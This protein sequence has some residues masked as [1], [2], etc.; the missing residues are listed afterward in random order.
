MDHRVGTRPGSGR[1]NPA[2]AAAA[3]PRHDAGRSRD[4]DAVTAHEPGPEPAASCDPQQR[5]PGAALGNRTGHDAGLDRR[6]PAAPSTPAPPAAGEPRL[7]GGVAAPQR[8]ALGLLALVAACGGGEAVTTAKRP[9][10]PDI[11]VETAA[12]EVKGHLEE[13]YTTLEG[14]NKDSLFSLLAD[15]L[16]A[17][18]PRPDDAL[19][20]RADVLT[21][22]GELVD[23]KEKKTVKLRSK[24]PTVVVAKGGRSAW[25]TDLVQV[26]GT[27]TAATIVLT[28]ADDLWLVETVAIA[29][30]PSAEELTSGLTAASIVPPGA[31][32]EKQIATDAKAAVA[33]FQAGLLDQEQWG[34][35]LAQRADAI[36]IGPAEGEVA[37]GKK[38]IKKRWKQR[39]EA[40]TRLALAGDIAAAVTADGQ[41]AWVSAPVT[42]ATAE[43]DPV[44]VRAF[45][46]Y[47]LTED[48][49]TMVALH[50]LVAVGEPGAGDK[51]MKILPPAT[52]E[53]PPTE[54][55][56]PAFE[57]EQPK[58]KK[59]KKK[60]PRK[61]RVVEDEE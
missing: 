18:G 8:F 40:K 55:P 60:K 16:Y 38:A 3:H 5:A 54:E 4:A 30:T 29:E 53:P 21:A 42:R 51:F 1:G 23:K 10:Q 19:A 58:K 35:E 49:W 31:Q 48:T 34:N 13:L 25:A 33:K 39:T 41:L 37:R 52:T 44:P 26:N 50:E 17:F 32:G 14:G 11:D 46:I 47:E 59:K 61:Q 22:L 56:A 27:A 24:G 36:V 45:A 43:G 57:D 20:T 15:P 12:A 28:N 2:A 9:K 7:R 6:R